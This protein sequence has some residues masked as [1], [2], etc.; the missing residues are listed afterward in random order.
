MP[1]VRGNLEIGEENKDANQSG[2]L[3]SKAD[4]TW[5]HFLPLVFLILIEIGGMALLCYKCEHP[6]WV[7]IFHSH[8][9]GQD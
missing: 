6:T 8:R 1:V 3:D 2:N 5:I 4:S 9:P 7:S